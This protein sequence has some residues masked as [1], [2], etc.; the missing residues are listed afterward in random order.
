M[1]ACSPTP[2]SPT[3][4]RRSVHSGWTV[5][6]DEYA[7]RREQELRRGQ[8]VL[9]RR[10]AERPPGA[11]PGPVSVSQPRRTT[12]RRPARPA[13]PQASG[14][15]TARVADWKRVTGPRRQAPTPRADGGETGEQTD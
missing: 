8:A 12:A 13:A 6:G 4:P 11:S 15:W 14:S 9:R 7:D 5:H 1:V 10:N 2:P 3:P